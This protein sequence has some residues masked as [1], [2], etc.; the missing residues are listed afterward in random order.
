M[1]GVTVTDELM[2]GVLGQT[3]TGVPPRNPRAPDR[4]PG[5]SSSGSACVVAAG[6][7][8]FALGTDTGGSVRVPAS[9]CGIYG[10]RPGWGQV[11]MDGVIPLAP[12][13]DTLGWFARDIAAMEAVRSVLLPD[14]QPDA[15]WPA[16]VWLPPEATAGLSSDLA[17]DVMRTATRL[18]KMMGLPL[19]QESLGSG[20]DQWAGAYKI[21]Q[22]IDTWLVYGDWIR[23]TRPALG[24]VA[25]KR[26][27]AASAINPQAAPSA[28]A[29]ATRL[30]SDVMP[31]LTDGGRVLLMPTTPCPAP[32][33][34]AI[35]DTLEAARA[36]VLARTA[37]SGMLG[38][39]ELSL[40][41]L[42]SE[43]A[44]VGLSMFSCP[45]REA[46]LIAL[47]ARI[48]QGTS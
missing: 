25:A 19:R 37:L 36:A 47:A 31:A 14:Q 1:E 8:D 17:D 41:W 11:A 18:A 20:P 44:P 12:R 32:R 23:N 34:D 45:G 2:F 16:A 38:L 6:L 40:P 5:G 42:S 30:A 48:E 35:D 13:F 29:I 15:G 7:R 21:L 46:G 28:E 43:G 10:L 27:A 4:L 39:A 26:F 33:R 24:P 3:A 22:G 9:F